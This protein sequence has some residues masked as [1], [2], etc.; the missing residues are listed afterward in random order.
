MKLYKFSFTL[1]NPLLFFILLLLWSACSDPEVNPE[2]GDSVHFETVPQPFPI[3]P[4]IIDEASG[5]ANSFSMPGY[6]WTLQD[7]G[8]PNSLYLLSSDGKTIKEYNIPGSTN[9]DWEDLSSGPGPVDGVTYL[10]IGEI[11]NNNPPMTATNLIYRVPEISNIN[12]SFSQSSL[13]KITFRYPDGPRD[14]ETL[15]LDPV[16]RDIFIVSKELDKAGLYRLAYPQSTTSTIVAEKI[17]NIPSVV[18]TTGGSVSVN[19]S[20][21]LIRNYTSA[22]YWVRNSGETIAQTLLKSPKKQMLLAPEP[23]GEAINFS[24]DGKGFYTLGEIGQGTSV[25]LNYYQRK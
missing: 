5:L 21:I 16:T 2:T 25:N 17:G 3:Q 13:E 4:G 6:L 7:S 22:F 23:Q 20:E 12:G 11:G 14:A 24:L 18:F 8:H 1:Q 15:L 19:G 9:H 10:Y